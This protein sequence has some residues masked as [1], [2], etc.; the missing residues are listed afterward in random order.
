MNKSSYEVYRTNWPAILSGSY[1]KRVRSRQ[2][3]E[4]VCSLQFIAAQFI[5][6][7]PACSRSSIRY[8][9]F[10]AIPPGCPRFSTHLHC[11]LHHWLQ[12]LGFSSFQEF[13]VF[14][15]SCQYS[16]GYVITFF[17]DGMFIEFEK[18]VSGFDFGAGLF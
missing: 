16:Y 10:Y 1:T 7:T 17:L 11:Y 13:H 12:F 8:A 2:Y 18:F 3:T 4:P 6:L 5:S 9:S 14:C 15:R